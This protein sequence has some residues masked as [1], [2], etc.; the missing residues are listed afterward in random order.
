VIVNDGIGRPIRM[1]V[2]PFYRE[3][4]QRV[5]VVPTSSDSRD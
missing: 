2:L 4:T 3:N 5:H 1:N